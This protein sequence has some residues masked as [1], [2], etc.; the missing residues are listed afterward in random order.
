MQ[1]QL[2]QE[3]ERLSA[4]I[5]ALE[6]EL[7]ETQARANEVVAQAQERV[8]WLDRW[9]LDLNAL[10]RRPGAAELRGALRAV[11]AVAR[12]VKRATRRL[13]S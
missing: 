6:E 11:R 12:M 10:M 9:H 13:S 1:E 2:Q 8:Y 7:A 5:G 4:R 3:N